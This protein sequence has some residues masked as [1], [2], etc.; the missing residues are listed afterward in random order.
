MVHRTRQSRKRKGGLKAALSPNHDKNITQ[1][2]IRTKMVP[3]SLFPSEIIISEEEN[4]KNVVEANL[5][6]QFLQFNEDNYED[7]DSVAKSVLY[8]NNI[9]GSLSSSDSSP[10]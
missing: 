8:K 5:A 2:S 6:E 3:T 1:C 10:K 4:E 9:H 7:S